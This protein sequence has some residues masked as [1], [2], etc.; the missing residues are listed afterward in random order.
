MVDKG[1][2]Q[3]KDGC[4]LFLDH[5]GLDIRDAKNDLSST[6]AYFTK[7]KLAPKNGRKMTQNTPKMTQN[8]S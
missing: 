8:C 4:P 5:G 7:K 6:D 1:F 2:S 3:R